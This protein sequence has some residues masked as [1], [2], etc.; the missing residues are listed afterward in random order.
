MASAIEPSQISWGLFE[1][2][3]A[4]ISRFSMLERTIEG[5][6]PVQMGI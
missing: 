4:T 6:K 2:G 1:L 5:V 3:H